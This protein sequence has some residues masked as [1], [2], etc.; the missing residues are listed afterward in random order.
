ME[1]LRYAV[2][3]WLIK[4]YVGICSQ[5]KQNFRREEI[6]IGHMIKADGVTFT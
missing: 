2:S 1:K 5:L 6:I 3:I 4:P